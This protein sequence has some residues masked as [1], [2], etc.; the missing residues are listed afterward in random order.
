MSTIDKWY[1]TIRQSQNDDVAVA[2]DSIDKKVHIKQQRHPEYDQD[3][4]LIYKEFDHNVNININLE[5]KGT[6]CPKC[7]NES[8]IFTHEQL[9][10]ADEGTNVIYKCI[11]PGCNYRKVQ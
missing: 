3:P 2:S 5:I 9:R 4:S 11:K 7:N 1:E 10:S 6:P 8:V